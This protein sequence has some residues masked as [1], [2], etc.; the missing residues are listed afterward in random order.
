MTVP[1]SVATGDL[2]QAAD[3]NQFKNL[4]EGAT[5]Y[6]TTFL[7][8]STSGTNFIVRLGD[9]IG[10]NK[11]SFQD[12]AGVEQ[13]S[14]NSDGLVTGNSISFASLQLPVSAA[15]APTTDG[16]VVWDSDDDVLTVGTGAATKVIGLLRG[17]GINATATRELAFN[18]TT[19][20]FSV[21]DGSAA[22]N[23]IGW[24]LVGSNTAEQTMTS[25]TAADLV[26]ITGLSI[27]VTSPVRIVGVFRKSATASQL[28]IGLKINATVVAEADTTAS[29]GIGIFPVTNEA[30]AGYFTVEF[31]PRSANYL[32]GGLVVNTTMSGATGISNFIRAGAVLTNPFPNAVIT[33]IIIRGDSDGSA[34]LGVKEVYV[35]QG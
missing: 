6:T 19:S 1:Y 33:D 14:I 2:V 10:V 25:A 20:Q 18:T 29:T 22:Q 7:L 23:V 16:Q 15:A 21:W 34:T 30:M 8:V 27:P 5:G 28:S 31:G 24:R 26:T 9:A 12:S 4:L 17:A 13:A 11:I 35:Y 32:V 3:V